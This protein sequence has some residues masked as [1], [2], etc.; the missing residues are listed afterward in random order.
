MRQQLTAV[1]SDCHKAMELSQSRQVQSAVMDIELLKTFLEVRRTRHFGRAAT[2]LFITQ[3]AVSVRIRQ[4]ESV[5]GAP[6]FSRQR[7]NIRLTETGERLVPHA[8]AMLNAWEQARQELALTR[9]AGT[10]L[11]IAAPPSLWD[12]LLQERLPLLYRGMPELVLRADVST[13]DLMLRRL[14]ENSL[15][16][17]LLY[18]LPKTGGMELHKLTE[19]TLV[20]VS[21]TAGAQLTDIPHLSYVS[22]DWGTSFGTLHY[23]ALPDLP[24]PRLHTSHGRVALEFLLAEG[25]SAYLPAPLCQQFLDQDQLYEVEGAPRFTRDVHAAYNAGSSRV[26]SI[27]QVVQL[28][29]ESLPQASGPVA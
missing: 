8:E 21:T 17:V 25:G 15:D 22:V 23:R 19:M 24:P 12:S 5:V 1:A 29:V 20:L 26:D 9:H 4:L 13:Q 16:L 11:S 18:D 2:N 10:R 3:S 27:R 6:L 7:N 14:L 28:L